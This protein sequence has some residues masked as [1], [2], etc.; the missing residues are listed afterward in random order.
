MPFDIDSH[1][2]TER[3]QL[4]GHPLFANIRTVE[5]V[6]TLM[7]VAGAECNTVIELKLEHHA[8]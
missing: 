4:F 7:A 2:E 1:I 8:A 5:D 6:R 3:A